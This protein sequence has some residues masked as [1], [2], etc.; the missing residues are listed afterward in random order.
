MARTEPIES[1]RPVGAEGGPVSGL[2]ALL[3]DVDG[4]LAET[5][6]DGHRVAFNLAFEDFGLGFRWD[7]ARYG[8]LLRVAGGRERLVA[9]LEQRGEP[10]SAEARET[11]AT[12]V[13]ER[14]NAYY[15]E[16]VRDGRLELRPGVREL[17]DE[18]DASGIAM[19]I[20]TTTGEDNLDALLTR[21][22]DA[23]WRERFATIVNG[24]H[25]AQKKPDPEVFERAIAE[26]GIEPSAAV[27]IEDSPDG[28]DAARRGGV[29]VIVTRSRYFRDAGFE[30]AV[31]IGP[32]LHTR[33]GWRP[34]PPDGG[35]RDGRIRLDDIT[36]WHGQALHVSTTG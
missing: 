13:H 3:W 25:V 8:E 22:L 27:A 29:P 30:G 28:A 26:L 15:G 17:M 32:G 34:E 36:A 1:G 24:D 9:D 23:D 19:G 4:T 14:K 21:Q 35:Q 7:D 16:L 18:C 33:A 11:L 2:K 20:T 12:Q 6:R 31:A 5:E 10:A